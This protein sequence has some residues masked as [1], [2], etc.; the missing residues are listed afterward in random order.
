[1]PES[2]YCVHNLLKGSSIDIYIFH[3]VCHLSLSVGIHSC[4]WCN[5]SRLIRL[6]GQI[7]EGNWQ[8]QREEGGKNTRS[9]SLWQKGHA[10][11]RVSLNKTLA[12][13][14]QPKC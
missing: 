13:V 10:W 12:G 11:G 6:Y 3:I 9:R 5:W 4:I 14:L 8:K 1:M 7:E 2:L